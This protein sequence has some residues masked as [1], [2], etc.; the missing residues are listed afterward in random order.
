[1][2]LSGSGSAG[3]LAR[4]HAVKDCPLLAEIIRRFGLC[5]YSKGE[6]RVSFKI[7]FN[8]LVSGRVTAGRRLNAVVSKPE[9]YIGVRLPHWVCKDVT[10]AG[11][12]LPGAIRKK[13]ARQGAGNQRRKAGSELVNERAIIGEVVLLG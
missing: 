11:A 2:H 3:T 5:G 1:V 9:V 13:W 6:G 4:A 10:A 8:Q 7:R 12:E